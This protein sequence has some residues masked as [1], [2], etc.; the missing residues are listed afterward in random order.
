MRHEQKRAGVSAQIIFEPLDGVRV[1]MIGR[2][3]ENQYVG[4]EDQFVRE[5]DTLSL[6]ARKRFHQKGSVGNAEPR[7]NI[8]RIRFDFPTAGNFEFVLQ[9]RN[10]FEFFIRVTDRQ[11]VTGIFVIT[12]RFHHAVARRKDRFENGFLIVKLRV[13]RQK[14]QRLPARARHFSGVRRFGAGDDF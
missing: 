5:R 12:N 8:S 9:A 3:V 13:L 2:F 7:Q 14:R 1:E 4:F 10:F 11:I 6:T